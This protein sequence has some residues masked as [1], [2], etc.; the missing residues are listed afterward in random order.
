MSARKSLGFT[1]VEVITVVLIIAVLAAIALPSYQKMMQ[2]SRRAEAAT[3]LNEQQLRLEKHRV[4]NA[5]YAT[6]ALPAGLDT[7]FYTFALADGSETTYTLTADPTG[8][9]ATDTCGMLTLEFDA[10]VV[11]HTQEGGSTEECW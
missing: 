8:P 4:D 3:V 5:S 6:Y 11:T 7:E 9:Q 10:G 2:R 1:L